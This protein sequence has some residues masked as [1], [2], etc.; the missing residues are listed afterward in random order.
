[1]TEVRAFTFTIP[2]LA[3]RRLTSNG[4]HGHWS[5]DSA[6]RQEMRG[7]TGQA[8]A[9]HSLPSWEAVEVSLVYYTVRAREGLSCCAPRRFKAEQCPTC[10]Q[11]SFDGTLGGESTCQCYR[12][13][14]DWNLFTVAK[15][16]IDSLVDA[17]VIPDDKHQ[18]AK[19]GTVRIRHCQ[20][21]KQE[22]IEVTVVRVEAEEEVADAA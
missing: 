12:P 21:I 8:L 9:G 10:L 2:G 16:I 14:D 1:M 11:R 19:V 5:K 22:R 20:S 15:P 4:P 7:F 18:N 6:G 13:T 17:G 3:H